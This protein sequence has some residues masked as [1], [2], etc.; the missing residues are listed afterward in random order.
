MRKVFRLLS[1]IAEAIFDIADDKPA[2]S[3]LGRYRAREMFDAGMISGTQYNEARKADA[4]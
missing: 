2:K 3:N 4:E 1:I